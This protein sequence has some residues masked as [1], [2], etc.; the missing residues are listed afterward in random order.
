MTLGN[1]ETSAAK[2]GR[3]F[4]MIGDGEFGRHRVLVVYFKGIAGHLV[5]WTGSC[6]G[7]HE[8]VDGQET[9]WYPF[10]EK[11]QCYVGAGCDECGHTG[12][13][14]R[15]EWV[16]ID[17]SDYNLSEEVTDAKP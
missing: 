11:A 1:S 7:C 10:D 17:P 6:T 16:P 2:P 13:R 5:R 3:E 8:T 14:R 15:E 12:K 9:G 4:R